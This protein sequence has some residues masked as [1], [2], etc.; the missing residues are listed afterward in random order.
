M[1]RRPGFKQKH[2]MLKIDGRTISELQNDYELVVD[3]GSRSLLNQKTRDL[4]ALWEEIVRMNQ[5]TNISV[6]FAHKNTVFV[7]KNQTVIVNI[8]NLFI[9]K[10]GKR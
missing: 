10:E 9:N 6:G 1:G 3:G 2:E 8:D 4:K 5:L 7:F